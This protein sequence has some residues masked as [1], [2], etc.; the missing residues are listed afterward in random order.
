[1]SKKGYQFKTA[2]FLIQ[3]GSVN[4]GPLQFNLTPQI[5]VGAVITSVDVKTYLRKVET[6]SY[7]IDTSHLAPAVAANVVTLFLKYPGDAYIG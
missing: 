6:T 2:T 3:P 1:M 5:P 7:L 4:V